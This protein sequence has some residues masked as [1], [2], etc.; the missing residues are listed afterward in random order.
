M[1]AEEMR[2][3]AESTNENA[4]LIGDTI[5]DTAKKIEE[6]SGASCRPRRSAW[7]ATSIW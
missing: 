3:L 7:P 5:G 1:V 2:K 6:V 4:V